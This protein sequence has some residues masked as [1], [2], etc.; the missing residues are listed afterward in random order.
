MCTRRHGQQVTWCEAGITLFNAV[1]RLARKVGLHEGAVGRT[2][3]FHRT[4]KGKD[5]LMV[6]L[7]W[8]GSGN[9]QRTSR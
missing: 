1:L 7:V 8:G 2:H 5:N 4:G 9:A 6:G 3:R